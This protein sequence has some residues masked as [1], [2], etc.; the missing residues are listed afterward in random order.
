[1][2]NPAVLIAKGASH[3]DIIGRVNL[4]AFLKIAR[5]DGIFVILRHSPEK[6]A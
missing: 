1:L 5:E 2:L 3:F 6:A 4:Q